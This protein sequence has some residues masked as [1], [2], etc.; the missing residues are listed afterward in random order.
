MK[1]ICYEICDVCNLWCDYCISSD[2]HDSVKEDPQEIN[3]FIKKLS[4]A[5]VVI[6]GGEPFL[7]S[8]LLLKLKLLRESLPN[9]FVSLSSN[10][11]IFYDFKKLKDYVDCIDISLPTLDHEVYKR[12]RGR[13]EV[14]AVVKNISRVAKSGFYTRVSC[15][16]TSLNLETVPELL[17]YLESTSINEVRLGRFFPFREAR[18]LNKKYQLTDIELADFMKTLPLTDY[19]FKAVPPISSLD[20]MEKGYLV[21]NYAGEVFFPTREG[22]NLLG[23]V[24]DLDLIDTLALEEQQEKIFVG[25][26]TKENTIDKMKKIGEK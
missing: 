8:E 9:S 7:D 6:A 17:D 19:S 4:P 23:M 10:G 18:R 11:T 24:R 20:L 14:E 1:S 2:N 5:R 12:M 26:S 3:E 13:D 16:L 21:V 22:R 25:M 15:M